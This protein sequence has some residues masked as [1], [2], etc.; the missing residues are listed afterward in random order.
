MYSGDAPLS[1]SL[2]EGNLPN[3]L[4]FSAGGVI[5]GTPTSAGVSE[6]TV[7]VTDADGD[8]A[9]R[10]FE[11]QIKGSIDI[12]QVS[13]A[14]AIDG[15]VESSWEDVPSYSLDN[16]IRGDEV[17]LFMKLSCY[18]NRFAINLL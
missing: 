14:P 10:S 13:N 2:T 16:T 6:I 5:S 4:N 7:Q 18:L 17:I 11:L 12:P 15:T 1:W 9:T 3:G 8:Q